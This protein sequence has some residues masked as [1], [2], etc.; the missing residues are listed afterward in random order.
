[1]KKLIALFLCLIMTVALVPALAVNE[2]VEGTVGIYSS[3]YPFVIDMM[4][5]ALKAEFPNLTPA[6]GDTFFFYA[7]TSTLITKVYG[8]M[9]TGTLG[10]D[11]LM[12]AEPAFSL[13]LKEAGYLQPIEVEGA[14][15]LL[16]FPYD[17]EGYWYPVRVCNM[18]LG[19]NPEMEAEWAAKG[20]TIPKTFKDFAFDTSLNGYISMGNPMTS[21]TTFAGIASLTQEDHYG[22]AYLD[23]LKANNVMIESGSTACTKLQ[24]GECACIMILEESILKIQKEAA[25]AGAPITN[26]A[27]IYPEDGVILIPSTVMTVAEEHSANCSIEACEAIENWLLSEAAQKLI[28]EG[29]MHSVFAG[30][31]DIPYNSVDTDGLIEK[32]LGVDWINADTNRTEINTQWTERVTTN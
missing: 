23:G 19:Y 17:A 26:L 14:D 30:M 5:E 12:V 11:M 29:Y 15:T 7:G 13:E 9:E 32:D 4:D 6:Y 27:V 21:G 16:R 2:D 25:D 22:Y 1:M 8:E 24:T 18:V 3:M 31:K 10:C 20:V 28:L